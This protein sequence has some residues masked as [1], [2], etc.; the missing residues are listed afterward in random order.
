MTRALGF[1]VFI[2][3]LIIGLYLLNFGLNVFTMPDF[4]LDIEKWII[5]V[6]GI[7]V[8]VGGIKYFFSSKRSY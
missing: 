2:V 5:F 6:G 8:I 1:I 7:L 4:I 3:Y